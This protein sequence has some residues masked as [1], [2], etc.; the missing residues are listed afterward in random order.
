[1]WCLKLDSVKGYEVVGYGQ[2][3]KKEEKKTSIRIWYK[4]DL[5]FSWAII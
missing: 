2:K 1:M 3:I 4:Y 5:S